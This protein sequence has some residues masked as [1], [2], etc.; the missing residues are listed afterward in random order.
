MEDRCIKHSRSVELC[1]NLINALKKY[2]TE[3]NC[4]LLLLILNGELSEEAW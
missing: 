4:K 2:Q 3:S 1:Y